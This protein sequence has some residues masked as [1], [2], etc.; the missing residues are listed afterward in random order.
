RPGACGPHRGARSP[1]VRRWTVPTH[2]RGGVDARGAIVKRGRQEGFRW[3]SR[4]NSWSTTSFGGKLMHPIPVLLVAL[5]ALGF[6]VN[7]SAPADKKPPRNEG[8]SKVVREQVSGQLRR[9]GEKILR[10]TGK[11]KVLDA[12]TLVFGDGTQVK[13]GLGMDAPDL[14]QKGL[15]GDSFYPCGKEAARFLTKLI[16]Q[17]TVTFIASKDQDVEAKKLR[18]NCFV[19]ET[20]LEIEMVRNGWAVAQHSGITAWEIIARE[21]KRGLWRGRFVLPDRWRKGE[22]LKGE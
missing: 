4:A 5:G 15:I 20:S 14:L 21:K 6:F 9:P 7:V 12:N 19:G 22:R 8:E 2:D 17:Q 16:G 3:L 13:T 11:A 18:G 10:I 1:R